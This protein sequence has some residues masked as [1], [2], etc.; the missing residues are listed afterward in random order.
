MYLCAEIC[1]QSVDAAHAYAVETARYLVAAFVELSASMEHCEHNLKGA[2]V[3]FLMHVYGYA[4][5]VVDHGNRVVPVDG[6]V[7]MIGKSCESLVNRVV[8]HLI[9]K[10]VQTFCAYIADIHRRAFPYG[11]KAFEHLDVT[12]AVFFFLF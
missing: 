6:D 3:L 9:Y 1:R 11:L 2:F 8:D 12:G 4:A 10:M 5:A 7:D